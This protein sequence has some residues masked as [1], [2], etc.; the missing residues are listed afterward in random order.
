M[1]KLHSEQICFVNIISDSVKNALTR[2]FSERFKVC[3]F[4]NIWG[5]LL[6]KKWIEK[7]SKM[8]EKSYSTIVLMF[9]CSPNT[10]VVDVGDK[11][12]RAAGTR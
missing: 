5:A 3:F 9:S 4:L 2:K 7:H 12:S 6:M 8:S 11:L 10:V 1:R